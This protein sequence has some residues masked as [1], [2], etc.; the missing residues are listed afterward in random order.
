MAGLGET[1]RS[2]WRPLAICPWYSASI[3]YI[4]KT[5]EHFSQTTN[6]LY[7]FCSIWCYFQFGSCLLGNCHIVLTKKIYNSFGMFKKQGTGN[8]Y[9][10]QSEAISSSF[11]SSRSNRDVTSFPRNQFLKWYGDRWTDGR[12][13]RRSLVW[14]RYFAS[15]NAIQK[16][17][18]SRYYQSINQSINHSVNQSINQSISDL[19]S[20]SECCSSYKL[21][22][23]SFH[24]R[25]LCE[26]PLQITWSKGIDSWIIHCSLFLPMHTPSAHWYCP[27]I[28]FSTI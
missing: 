23:A 16:A 17:M 7:L 10:A 2:P 8:R 3:R 4:D 27:S 26:R 14:R 19:F 21:Q 13:D 12:T 22:L 20:S 11:S 9:Q 6:F 28:P 15:K 1:L 5:I 18:F 24:F 25:R